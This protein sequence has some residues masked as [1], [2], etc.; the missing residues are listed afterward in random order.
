MKT[1]LTVFLAGLS[2]TASAL[3]SHPSCESPARDNVEYQLKQIFPE[4]EIK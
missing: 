2:A 1:A 3:P 4:Y